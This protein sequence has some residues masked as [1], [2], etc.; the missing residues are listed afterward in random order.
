MRRVLDHAFSIKAL[1]EQNPVVLGFADELIRGLHDQITGPSN[2]KVDL[3]K[4]YNWMSFDLI[5][6]SVFG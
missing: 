3:V 1:K 6:E 5:G 4:W 2:G